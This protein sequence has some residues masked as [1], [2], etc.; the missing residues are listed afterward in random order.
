MR[1]SFIVP[2]PERSPRG[3]DDDVAAPYPIRPRMHQLNRSGRLRRSAL[4]ACLTGALP[5]SLSAQVRRPDPLPPGQRA[6][7]AGVP[8]RRTEIF[9][10]GGTQALSSAN[11]TTSSI[12][13]AGGGFRRQVATKW[14]F[15]GATADIGSTTIDGQFFPYEKRLIGDTTQFSVVDGSATMLSARLT[16]DAIVPVGDSKR[17]RYGGGVNLGIYAMNPT[18]AAGDEAGRF[19]A[20]TF[21]LSAL[22]EADITRR[23][24]ATAS[25]GFAQFTGFDREKLRPSNPALADP[26]FETPFS[27]P[28][29]AAKSFGGIR[30][31]VGLTYRLGVKSVPGGK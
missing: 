31:V 19:I 2:S 17:L 11:A 18:P 6:A 14:L 5:L 9:L 21:G 8:T 22:G 23:I 4:L 16:A 3:G 1:L 20:P 10:T 13:I 7:S 27:A 26:V 24:G 25:L 29:A 15:L 30:V 28:P 12:L